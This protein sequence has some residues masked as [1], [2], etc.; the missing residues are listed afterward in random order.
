M[1]QTKAKPRI[2]LCPGC[3]TPFQYDAELDC[4]QYNTHHP[5]EKLYD[6]FKGCKNEGDREVILSICPSC[7]AVIGVCVLDNLGSTCYTP[8]VKMI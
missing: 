2:D 1:Q 6:P 7:N 3:K 5:T 4:W 8:I